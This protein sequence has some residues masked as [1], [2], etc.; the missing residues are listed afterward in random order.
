MKN[1]IKLF[2][3]AALVAFFVTSCDTDPCK[4]VICGDFGTC[5]E[6][7]CICD[8]GYEQDGA[9]QCATIMRTKFLGNFSTTENCNSGTTDAY[10]NTI[11]ESTEGISRI[12]IGNFYNFANNT[13][14]ATVDGTTV[15]IEDQTTPDNFQVVGDGSIAGDVLSISFIITD[16]VNGG[17]DTC[18]TTMTRQ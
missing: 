9:G 5:V 3:F 17:S 8:A 14:K 6:G 18:L 15:T 12:T 13:V 4:N 7:I 10:V 11:S 2:S 16:N 1:L